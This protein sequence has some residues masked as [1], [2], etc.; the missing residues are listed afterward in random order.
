MDI[1]TPLQGRDVVIVEDIVDTGLTLTTLRRVLETRDPASIRT[2]ALLDKAPRR[3]VDVPVEY[4]GFEVGDEFLLG[5]GLDWNGLV[6]QRAVAVGSDGS[7]RIDPRPPLLRDRQSRHGY[8]L[9]SLGGDRLAAWR[10]ERHDSDGRGRGRIELP[11]NTPILLLRERDGGRFLPIWIGPNEATAIALALEG[12]EPQRPMTHDLLKLVTESLGATVDRV[13]VTDLRTGPSSPTS[14]SR[15]GDERS[16]SRRARPMPS[17]WRPGLVTV[18]AA[19]AVLDEGG[20]EIRDEGQ[21]EEIERFRE[22]L[23]DITQMTSRRVKVLHEPGPQPAGRTR[24]PVDG[25]CDRHVGFML[26]EGMS[27]FDGFYLT[28]ITI[29][30]LGFGPGSSSV[31]EA[32][33]LPIILLVLGSA[34]FSTLPSLGWNWQ[35][36]DCWVT[37]GRRRR[38]Q[39]T[40]ESLSG[41]T[42]V[43]G[44][45]QVGATTWQRLRAE[46]VDVCR[47][48]QRPEAD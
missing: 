45:G 34:V 40:I 42:I 36:T 3:I 48:R 41:H 44:Y 2:V 5:Y 27:P 31:P 47:H 30:T 43:C 7:R 25:C 22:F 20:V 9:T 37:I 28:V 11:T 17:R 39:R 46:G 16:P 26:I 14:S 33:P 19:R 32:A 1:A 10:D 4:R 24:T 12:V 35:S 13:V 8:R 6:S 15:N 29:S 23:E 18:F 21:E 38:M